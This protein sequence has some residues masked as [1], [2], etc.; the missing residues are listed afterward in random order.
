MT[1][2]TPAFIAVARTPPKNPP[3]HH[4]PHP[5]GHFWRDPLIDVLRAAAIVGFLTAVVLVR[6]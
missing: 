5:L 2:C 3:L 6:L 4:S 1:P